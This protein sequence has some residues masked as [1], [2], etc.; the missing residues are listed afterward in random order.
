MSHQAR[1]AVLGAGSWGTALASHL[2]NNGHRVSLWGRDA[3]QLNAMAATGQNA[4]YLPDV[5]LPNTLRYEADVARCVE[6][7]D[8]ILLVTPSHIFGEML[9]ELVSIGAGAIPLIWACKGLERGSGRRLETLATETLEAG[10]PN[11]IIS[12]PT[13]ARELVQGLPTAITVASRDLE[14]AGQVVQWL[15]SPT[16][17]AYRSDDVTGVE[18]GGALKNVFAIAAGISDGLGFGANARAA[19]INRALVELMRL[20]VAMGGRRETFMG[21]AGMGDLVLTCT[22]DQSRNRRMGLA[23]ARGLSVE[24]ALEEIGQAVEGV[25]TAEEAMRLSRQYAIEMPIAE[26]VYAVLNEGK[27]P[28]V[29][30]RDLLSRAPRDELAE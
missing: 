11:A 24:A 2:A 9:R 25:G 8:A 20:G 19:L 7:S 30:V 4:R 5:P 17:R 10:V 28:D 12:G 16:F 21:L 26:Q 13:F 22:D 1:I 14:F 3:E 29:A 27:R 6:T 15:H 23:L 18:I